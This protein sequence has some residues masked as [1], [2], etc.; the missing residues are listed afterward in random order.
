MILRFTHVI[1]PTHDPEKANLKLWAE[2][3]IKEPTFRGHAS[4]LRVPRFINANDRPD[5]FFDFLE[6]L[7]VERDTLPLDRME[8]IVQAALHGI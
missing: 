6:A 4:C 1:L 8:S 5:R 2:C 7:A 3:F